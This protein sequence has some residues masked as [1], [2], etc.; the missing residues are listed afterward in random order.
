MT[1]VFEL[2]PGIRA[3]VIAFSICARTGQ[4]IITYELEYQRF[5]HAEFM[6]HREFSR[7]AMSSR[8]IPIKKMIE[9]V[10]NNPAKPVHWGKNQ[11][12]M[13]ANVELDNRERG[14]VEDQWHSAAINAANSAATMD[15]YGAHKQVANRILEPF[16][17]MKTVMTTTSLVN[18]DWL[19]DHAD[20]DPTI[21][22][23][24]VAMIEA[25]AA[26]GKPTVLN[27][28][29]WHVPYYGNGVWRDSGYCNG[30][31]EPVY[32][33]RDSTST[34]ANALAIS[35][36]CC[37]QVSYRLLDD[38]R[39]KAQMIYGKLVE[40]EPVH[41]SPFEH[42]ATPIEPY[43]TA[44]KPYLPARNCH[45]MPMGWQKGITHVTREGKFCSGN[46]TNFIQHRQLI[47]NNVKR[48]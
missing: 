16:Q 46:F 28:G 45:T 34:L 21:R 47:P 13:Q 39:E 8:A 38:T 18:W 9:Q 11:P 33:K 1:E 10:R 17:W 42:Q 41:A 37:A 44:R 30:D 3:K 48:G 24:A 23:L 7:N 4:T 25:K 36:S 31:M 35:S 6:T 15:Q 22:A 2:K 43:A 40:S 27:V 19:R 12:G 29:D 14:I 26:F 20:A 5:I 32:N